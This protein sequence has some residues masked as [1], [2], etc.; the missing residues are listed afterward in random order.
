MGGPQVS[1]GSALGVSCSWAVNPRGQV[2]ALAGERELVDAGPGQGEL[3][4][5][6]TRQSGGAGARDA[7]SAGAPRNWFPP[8][9]AAP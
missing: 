5:G 7:G 4:P 9:A 8:T 1:Q 2:R 3:S 6:H